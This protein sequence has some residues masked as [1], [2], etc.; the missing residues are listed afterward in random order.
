MQLHSSTSE[1]LDLSPDQA[2]LEFTWAQV[3]ESSDSKGRRNL[4]PVRVATVTGT[5]LI[6][7]LEN[8]VPLSRSLTLRYF[9]SEEC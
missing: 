9:D 4:V 6:Q 7:I 1:D 2:Q 5:H 3:S 8:H